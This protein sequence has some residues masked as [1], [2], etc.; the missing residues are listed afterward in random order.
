MMYDRMSIIVVNH[1]AASSACCGAFNLLRILPTIVLHFNWLIL[2]LRSPGIIRSFAAAPDIFRT[3]SKLRSE[4]LAPA[5]L[6][7]GSM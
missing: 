6:A 4:V 1:P 2:W 3:F 7:I 5:L